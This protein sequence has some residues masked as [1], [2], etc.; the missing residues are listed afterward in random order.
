M[1][2]N[3]NSACKCTHTMTVTQAVDF[4]TTSAPVWPCGVYGSTRTSLRS[5]Q[6]GPVYQEPETA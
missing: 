6:K 5:C 2:E 3:V 1:L 4:H